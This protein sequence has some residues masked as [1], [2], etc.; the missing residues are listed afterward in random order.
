MPRRRFVKRRAI[1]P[2]LYHIRSQVSECKNIRQLFFQK[3]YYFILLL[4]LVIYN[5]QN[6]HYLIIL[7]VTFIQTEQDL[8]SSRV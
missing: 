3:P 2:P 4:N 7:S 5:C 6:N 1:E 8:H